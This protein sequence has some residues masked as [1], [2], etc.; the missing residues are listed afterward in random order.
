M[1]FRKI[2]LTLHNRSE[3]E[4]PTSIRSK[5]VITYKTSE[6]RQQITRYFDKS[7]EIS[8]GNCGIFNE[9]ISLIS[10]L[11]FKKWLNKK[12]YGTLLC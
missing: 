9:K 4:T 1:D 12:K 3:F 10:D 5:S 11:D 7:Q 6:E 2:S 8:E